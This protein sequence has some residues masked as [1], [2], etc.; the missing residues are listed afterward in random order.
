MGLLHVRAALSDAAA[1][2]IDALVPPSDAP[3]V[4]HAALWPL[5]VAARSDPSA[6]AD[7]FIDA[8]DERVV[9]RGRTLLM[10]TETAGYVDGRCDLDREPSIT[11][12]LSE[13]F[14][15]RPGVRRTRSAFFSFA[16]AGPQAAELCALRPA[17]ALGCGSTYAWLQSRDA[18]FVLLGCTSTTISYLHRGEWLAR[19]TLPYRTCKTV[20]G[21][22]RVE[23]HDEPLTETL[24][25]RSREPEARNDFTVLHPHFERAGLMRTSFFG[26]TLYAIDAQRALAVLL[27]RLRDDPLFVLANREDFQ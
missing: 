23:G 3:V 7:A 25:V 20:T 21:T 14:R 1:A 2:A 19:A 24:H 15:G 12:A 5:A 17:D 27:E 8:L 11:G 13:R 10:P 6:V 9:G 4:V 22:I 26:V 16:V 18:R